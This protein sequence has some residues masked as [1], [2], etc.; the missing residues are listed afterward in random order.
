MRI[1][2]V[3]APQIALQ[4]VLRRDPELRDSPLALADGTGE[5]ARITAITRAAFRQ[6]VRRGMLVCQAR[7]AGAGGDR[8]KVLPAS[9]A[10]RASTEAA[11][12]DLGYGFAP[13]VQA[14]N[15]RVFFDCSDI[16]RLYPQGE[17]AMAQAIAARAARIGLAVRVAIAANKGVAR[18]ASCV[19]D[20][21]VVPAGGEAAHMAPLPVRVACAGDEEVRL[22]RWGIRTLGSLAR[23]PMDAVVLRLGQSGARLWRLANGLDDEPLMASLP[24]DAIEEGTEFDYAIYELEPLSFILRGLLDRAF[25][26]LHCRNLGCAG[27]TL[28]FK[29]DPHG[30]EVRQVAL[31]A[32]SRDLGPLL[33]LARLELSRRPPSGPVVG[34]ALLAL[35]ARVKSVQLDFLRPS[36]PAPERMAT[37]LARLAALV[38]MDNVGTPAEVD[39]YR[40][41]AV[42][43]RP[44]APASTPPTDPTTTELALGFRR[45]RPPQE[46]EVLMG[47]EGPTA[48]RG[49]STTARILLAA[50][51]YRVSGEWWAGEGFSRDYWDVHASDGAVYRLHQ[52]RQSGRWFLDGYYD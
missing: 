48:L 2:C 12:A 3:Y 29:L 40:E 13:R 52:D 4:A 46:M 8:L 50:G 23:L 31:G 38:G 18:L 33:E 39:S 1:A 20:L 5:R 32:P 9:T 11:L 22:A 42:A 6:G 21:A 28:R 24:A 25:A 37:T 14:E 49:K 17:Q 27:V 36:G 34:L 44:F 7:A 45:F 10:D 19:Q 16:Q 15:E 41:E 35:P 43:V 26:R 47:R 30:F 51:P